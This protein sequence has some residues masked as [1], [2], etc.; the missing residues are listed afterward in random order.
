VHGLHVSPERALRPQGVEGT[1]GS[2]YRECVSLAPGGAADVAP[3]LSEALGSVSDVV[4]SFTSAQ[5]RRIALAAQGF[6]RPLPAAPGVRQLASTVERLGILQLDSVNVF[7][8]SHYLPVFARLGAYSKADLDR[9]TFANTRR[10]IEYWA[11]EASLIPLDTLPLWRWK[12]EQTRER[13]HNDPSS[14]IHANK[15]MLDWL[16][17]ELA[18]T[19][20]LPASRIEYDA[21]QRRGGWWEW[22]D[23]KRGLEFL[24]AWGEVVSAGRT[25]FERTYGLAEQVLPAAVLERA[26]PKSDAIRELMLRASR[27]HGIGTASDLSDYYRLKSVDTAPVLR[28]LVDEGELLPVTV[29]G[30][31][32]TGRN[33]EVYLHRDARIPRRIDAAALLSPFDPVV[34]ERSRA[35]RMF[36][37][38]YRIEIYTPEHKRI[39]GYYTLPVLIDDRIV[40]RIDLKN[41]RQNGV[42]RVQSAWNEAGLASGSEERIVE[43]LRRAAN[44]QGL[45]EIVVVDRGDL[46]RPLAAELGQ[47]VLP[48]VR[49]LPTPVTAEA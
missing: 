27:A 33:R 3:N 31:E 1:A 34:W 23:V 12:M 40:A 30:W 42:L 44:W 16:R 10:Y 41:D 6:G 11:H 25:R 28:D 49:A 29:A 22:S 19:G 9:L 14:W 20:P 24:F 48:W 36:D 2:P 47:A 7:E 8:R 32:T 35:L 38:H 17:A 18:S 37:F 43:L 46:A 26:V 21:E 13:H 39:F 5:A 45:G 4:T 15:A